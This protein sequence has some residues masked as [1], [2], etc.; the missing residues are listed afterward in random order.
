MLTE[1]N[2]IALGLGIA[3]SLFLA[4]ILVQRHRK[5]YANR[6]LAAL[7]LVYGVVLTQLLLQDLGIFHSHSRLFIALSALPLT[8]APLHYLYARHLIHPE[9][10]MARSEWL[11]LIPFLLY[12]LTELPL[13][14]GPPAEVAAL[15]AQS[16][17][18]DIPTRFFIFNWVIILQSVAYMAATLLLLRRHATGLED[19]ASSLENLRLNWLRNITLLTLFAW[20]LFFVEYV[21]YLGGMTLGPHFGVSGILG[22]VLVYVLG[23]LGLS[24]S[25]VLE[26][27]S[28]HDSLAELS[29]YRERESEWQRTGA[30][31]RG[32]HAAEVRRI[33]R[34]ESESIAGASVAGE[35]SDGGQENESGRVIGRSSEGSDESSN[36][37]YAKSGLGED[38]AEEA[39]AQLLKIMEE[40]RVYTDSGLTLPHL[41]GLVGVTPHNLSEV[42]NTRFQQNFFDFVNS[43]RLRQVQADLN[44]PA[45]QNLT[46]LAI[47]FDAGFNS[48]TSFNTIFKKHVGMTPSEYRGR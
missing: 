27:S 39:A 16:D 34:P 29:Q 17:T 48:K 24:R 35:S 19:L 11:H 18:M 4:G 8:A 46:V 2:N 43:Y 30:G 6:F 22:G 40:E 7:M 31:G 26:A 37:R 13:L 21:F 28:V 15:L 41:A 42:I 10:R 47:A 9:K 1:I 38:R 25:E 20:L 44:D 3:Q 32:R 12:K 36:V 14:F 23:Y 5:L 33:V 45:K